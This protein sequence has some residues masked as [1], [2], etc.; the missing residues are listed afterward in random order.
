MCDLVET[1]VGAESGGQV[2]QI[3]LESES[4][5]QD[6]G[7]QQ[8]FSQRFRQWRERKGQQVQHKHAPVTARDLEHRH[9][10]EWLPYR[11][12]LRVQAHHWAPTQRLTEQPELGRVRASDQVNFQFHRITLHQRCLLFLLFSFTVQQNILEEI[13]NGSQKIVK[14]NF[15]QSC[16]YLFSPIHELVLLFQASCWLQAHKFSVAHEILIMKMTLVI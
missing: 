8:Q 10:R 11:L 6:V 12:P 7:A 5:F 4:E 2:N 16:P 13:P 1:A 14:E 9:R 15:L 3:L